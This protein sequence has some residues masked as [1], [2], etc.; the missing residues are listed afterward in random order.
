V[1]KKKMKTRIKS[2]RG[3]AIIGIAMAAIMVASV[4]V[5]MVP[6]AT[7]FTATDT[8]PAMYDAGTIQADVITITETADGEFAA[9]D[10]ITITLPDHFTLS[11]PPAITTA[12]SSV[13]VGAVTGVNGGTTIT[14]LITAVTA[15]V[16]DTLVVGFSVNVENDAFETATF[17]LSDSTGPAIPSPTSTYVTI[18]A[19]GGYSAKQMNEAAGGNILIGQKIFFTGISA[20][21]TRITITGDTTS[22]S[23][24]SGEVFSTAVTIPPGSVV[25]V[26]AFDT[27]GHAIHNILHG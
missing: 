18:P 12:G 2:E 19:G 15:V 22:G 24:T 6:T 16:L 23:T 27:Y 26:A 3:K 10:T 21:A 11:I 5:A 1:K 7:A 9:G 4:M 13:T 8:L 17:T 25:E 14:I 20:G